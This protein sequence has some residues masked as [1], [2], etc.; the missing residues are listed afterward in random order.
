MLELRLI[1][2]TI[3]DAALAAHGLQSV[4]KYADVLLNGR[5]TCKPAGLFRLLKSKLAMRGKKSQKQSMP[6]KTTG[7]LLPKS[8]SGPS[9][10][11]KTRIG[12]TEAKLKGI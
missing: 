12:E 7:P 3:R 11:S 6:L 2:L 10:P 4:R 1:N 5:A 8:C 9:R